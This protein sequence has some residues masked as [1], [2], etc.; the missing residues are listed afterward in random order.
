MKKLTDR[1]RRKELGA[2]A[3][4][5]DREIDTSDIPELTDEQLSNAVRGQMYRPVKKPVTMRLDADVIHWLKS[6][7]PGYQTKANQLLRAEML[8]SLVRSGEHRQSFAGPIAPKNAE[9]RA[10]RR[11]RG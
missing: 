11:R 4:I 6:Q 2:I 7:G 9:R 8:R 3:A 10:V 5:P 1:Q